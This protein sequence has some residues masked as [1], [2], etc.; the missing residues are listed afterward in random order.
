M[1][2]I[3]SMVRR[4]MVGYLGYMK[5]QQPKMSTADVDLAFTIDSNREAKRGVPLTWDKAESAKG[6][7]RWFNQYNPQAKRQQSINKYEDCEIWLK[8]MDDWIA[9]IAAEGPDQLDLPMPWA[10]SETG[11]TNSAEQRKWE[12]ANTDGCNTLMA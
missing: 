9:T 6:R 2:K 7:K 10:P 4:Y 8:V 11:Y 3:V 5:G 12:Q 1:E